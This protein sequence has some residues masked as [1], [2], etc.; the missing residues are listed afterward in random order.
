MSAAT[1]VVSLFGVV[2]V[3]V[4]GVV[5]LPVPETIVSIVAGD[6]IID[7]DVADGNITGDN[8]ADGD[9]AR[10]IVRSIYIV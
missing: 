9:V 6:N 10:C 1:V 8:V 3:A 2:I 5:D 7:G 4:T